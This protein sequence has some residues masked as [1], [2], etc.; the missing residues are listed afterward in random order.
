[1]CVMKTIVGIN[2]M[3]LTCIYQMLI[4]PKAAGKNT[5]MS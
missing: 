4:N 2:D 3:Y 1:M 5:F